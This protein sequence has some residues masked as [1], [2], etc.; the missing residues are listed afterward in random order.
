MTE[1]LATP[2]FPTPAAHA[3]RRV[4]GAE[5]SIVFGATVGVWLAGSFSEGSTAQAASAFTDGHLLRVVTFEALVA[6]LLVP[7]LRRRGWSPRDVAGAP[8]LADVARG[9]GVWGLAFA[10]YAVTW[11]LFALLQRE[12]AE[13]LAIEQRF[14]GAPASAAAII[15]VSIVNPVFEEFL[16]LG[17][18][19]TRLAPRLGLRAAA[20]LSVGLRAIVHLYQGPWAVLGVLP[21]GVAFTWYFGRTRRLWP[22]VVAHAL[23]DAIG[24]AL[25]MSTQ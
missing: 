2:S 15:L 1:P 7:W 22:V 12:A 8:G 5:V 21:V 9:V 25:R 20:A 16:W 13:A 4:T 17:Y 14:T 10:C 11:V 3:P 19:V 23:F 6:A 18:G 24:L